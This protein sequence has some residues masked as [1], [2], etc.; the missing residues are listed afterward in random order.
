M[1]LAQGHRAGVGSKVIPLHHRYKVR[2]YNSSY[3]ENIDP[4][5]GRLAPP[6]S[7]L[8]QYGT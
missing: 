6:K 1:S 4:R 7:T 3:G 5:G 2:E 8:N